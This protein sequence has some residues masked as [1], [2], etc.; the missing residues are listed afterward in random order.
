MP[1]ATKKEIEDATQELLE[2]MLE[3]REANECE[4]KAKLRKIKA[5]KRLNL[6]REEIR[7]INYY[8]Y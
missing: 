3:V 1:K 8:S 5:H 7:A 2:A 4:D 6:A